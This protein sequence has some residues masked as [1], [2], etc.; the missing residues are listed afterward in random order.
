MTELEKFRD[1]N[2]DFYYNP[3]RRI[4]KKITMAEKRVIKQLRQMCQAESKA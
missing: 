2:Y 4:I 3:P 1:P